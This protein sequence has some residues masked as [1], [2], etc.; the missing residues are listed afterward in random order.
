[1][2]RLFTLFLFICIC[3]ATFAQVTIQMERYNNVY[4]IPCVVNGAKMKFI[5]DTGAS[6]VS[7]SQVMAEYL[8]DNDMLNDEDIL[9]V[10]QSS[11]ADGRIVNHLN[12]ILRDIE[13][14]GLHLKNVKAVVTEG[15][16]APLLLGQ[17]AIQQLGPITIN[18]DKLTI[19]N[20]INK[21]S[22]NSIEANEIY[23][24]AM[25]YKEKK[26]YSLQLEEMLKIKDFIYSDKDKLIDLITCYL[27]NE[28]IEEC[29][30]ASLD[31]LDIFGEIEEDYTYLIVVY[32]YL[33]LT[34]E[35]LSN[36]DKAIYYYQK[37]LNIELS[38][39]LVYKNFADMTYL[40]LGNC[41]FYDK[42]YS[43]ALDYYNKVINIKVEELKKNGNFDDFSKGKY[44]NLELGEIM[45]K[46]SQCYFNVGDEDK[47]WLTMHLAAEL[48][49]AEASS[50]L[51]KSEIGY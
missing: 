26:L 25:S 2:K 49:N 28:D 31:W 45:F 24:K 44:K 51:R 13:I 43:K 29:N 15:L 6:T 9:D 41:Y 22:Y 35:D 7:I 32:S 38:D 12:I 39:D 34:Y 10:G 19:N 1:M 4:R 36:W 50:I 33:G 23:D 27:H 30:Q 5:F 21:N 3:L 48:G 40:G 16:S 17:S 42:N 37:C 11:V 20:A 18:G 47:W 8:Y 46:L 14:A